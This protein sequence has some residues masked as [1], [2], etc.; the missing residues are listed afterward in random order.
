MQSLKRISLLVTVSVL[1]TSLLSGCA[2]EKT[3]RTKVR[4]LDYHV[5]TEDEIPEELKTQIE[6]KK[7]AD[8]K[9]TYETPEHLYIV[10]GYGEQ[11]TGGYSIQIK[12]LYLTSNAVFF[13]TELI[14]PRKGEN[15]AKS[16]SYPYIVVQ[17]EKVDKNVVFE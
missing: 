2:I 4:D 8:F 3:N 9:L 13:S 6:E 14:G 10:R 1:L 12:E 11:E 7:A 17:T 5:V 15:V 16:P